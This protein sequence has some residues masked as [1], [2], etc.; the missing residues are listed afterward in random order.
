MAGKPE[1]KPTDHD[2]QQ[3]EPLAGYGIP[4][5]DIAVLIINPHTD[6]HI[7]KSTLEK[8]FEAELKA[9]HIKAN[10]KIAESLYKQATEGNVTAGIWWSKTRMGWKET[11]VHEVNANVQHKEIRRVIVNPTK[12]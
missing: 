9:G 1:F 6:S 2:R 10:A 11:N 12:K 3:V 8:H 5:E 7:A 4:K